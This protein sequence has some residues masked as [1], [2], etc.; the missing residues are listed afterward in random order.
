MFNEHICKWKVS[1]YSHGYGLVNENITF[2]CTSLKSLNILTNILLTFASLFKEKI[3]EEMTE[4]F[5]HNTNLKH[6]IIQL[7]RNI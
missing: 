5:E 6:F 7:M 2:I 3:S 1:N 4:I